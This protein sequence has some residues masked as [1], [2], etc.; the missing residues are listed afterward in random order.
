M[1]QS[2]IA[3]ML[4]TSVLASSALG[5]D[6]Q[7]KGFVLGGGA[8][9]VPAAHWSVDVDFFNLG[10]AKVDEDRVGVGV[11]FII[12]GAFD[13]HN[14]L[15]YEGN[16]SAFNSDLLDESVAQGFNGAAWYHY[17]GS[18]V[19]SGFTA[20]GLGFCYFKVGEYDATDPGMALLVGGGYEFSP[21]WQV[22]AYLTFGGTSEKVPGI[23]G[24]FEHSNLSVMVTGIAF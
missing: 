4:V 16:V 13:E 14:M 7:R 1:K 8:G 3:A 9:I 10:T 23:K 19:N 17:F 5:F 15:V 2:L 24:E 22:G 20:V 21:H 12:G 11:Q 6:G 18:T